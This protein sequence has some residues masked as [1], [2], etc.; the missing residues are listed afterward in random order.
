[1]PWPRSCLPSLPEGQLRLPAARSADRR[2][3]G[4]G[5]AR[6]G[7]AGRGA[8]RPRLA[9]D[10]R[11]ADAPPRRPRPGAGRACRRAGGAAQGGRGGGRRPPAAAP[12]PGSGARRPAGGR[13]PCGRGPRR[14]GPH[15]RPS[16][17]PRPGGRGRLHRRQPDGDGLRAGLRGQPV[18]DV[19]QPRPTGGAA[20]RH[21]HPFRPRLP[22]CQRRLRPQRRSGQC[23]CRRRPAG[24]GARGRAG[25]VHVT[26]DVERA[27]N[28]FL[29][30]ALPAAAAAIGMAGAPAAVFAELRRRK[31]RF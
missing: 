22:R 13:Q 28:P 20:G 16:C 18:D 31:D 3:R 8:C 26:L 6:G 15:R 9:A 21:P 1:M 19:G 27:T 12:R 11:A 30:A 2:D 10:R 23:G 25:G 29:R 4:G 24:R 7:A 5:R 17:L 14:L